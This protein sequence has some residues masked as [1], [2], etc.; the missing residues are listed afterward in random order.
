MLLIA[1]EVDPLILRC[2][3]AYFHHLARGDNDKG[4]GI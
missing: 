1:N 3:H 2:V 4:L